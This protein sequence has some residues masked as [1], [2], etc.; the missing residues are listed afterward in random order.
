MP[1][2][3][4]FASAWSKFF[5]FFLDILL[6]T[7]QA[8]AANKLKAK[9]PITM[10]MIVTML[11]CSGFWYLTNYGNSFIEMEDPNSYLDSKL[12]SFVYLSYWYFYYGLSKTGWYILADSAIYCTYGGAT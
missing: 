7:K 5:L 11:V 6:L 10:D 2:W 8:I 3:T 4:V 9:T 1:S 12:D